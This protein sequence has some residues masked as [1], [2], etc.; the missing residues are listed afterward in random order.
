MRVAISVL[1]GG[2]AVALFT[3]AAERVGSRVGGL[4]LSFPVKVTVALALIGLNEGASFAA[5]AAVQVP[6]GLGVNAVFLVA[7]ALLVRRFAPRRALALAL[8]VWLVAAV[9]VVAW[10]PRSLAASV[11]VW[12]ACAGGGLALLAG[13]AA[14]RGDR[15]ARVEER[16]GWRALLSRAA[17][18]GAI[19]GLSLVLARLG[20][21]VLG[22][23]AS[24]F[25]S[26]WIT[27][28]VIL[29]HRH[30]AD[31]TGA[32]VRVMLAGSLA[33][34]LFGVVVALGYPAWG[35][36]LGTVAG[37][38]AALATSLLVMGALRWRDARAA[39]ARA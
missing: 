13:R 4:L 36:A 8:A 30:G 18:A 33:P 11:A 16:F 15:R 21:P 10:P 39:G 2:L 6:A 17:G 22:G 23:L 38:G 27:T 29:S 26:G 34:V 25:P 35:V 5:E 37:M 3:T 20:G 1:V 31:F 32:T 12:L 28:M 24:V 19:V 7:T 9:A 14:F